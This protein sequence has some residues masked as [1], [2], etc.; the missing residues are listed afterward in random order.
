MAMHWTI[1]R[2]STLGQGQAPPGFIGTRL[3]LRVTG[4]GAIQPGWEPGVWHPFSGE[5]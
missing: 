2:V 5:L 1:Q 3:T 4:L